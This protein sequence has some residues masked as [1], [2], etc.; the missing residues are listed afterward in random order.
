MAGD[1]R[2]TGRAHP[3][4]VAKLEVLALGGVVRTET[5]A[6]PF[7]ADD[8]GQGAAPRRNAS[9]ALYA[10]AP[11]GLDDRMTGTEVTESPVQPI[12]ATMEPREGSKS[13]IAVAIRRLSATNIPASRGSP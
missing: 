3:R 10:D 9:P 6:P 1:V 7:A 8:E 5:V 13:R 11:S 12:I 4:L 2:R